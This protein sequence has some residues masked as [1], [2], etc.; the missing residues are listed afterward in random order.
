MTSLSQSAFL[1]ALGWAIAN[2]L[3]QMALLWAAYQLC[4]VVFRR[5]LASVKT[6]AATLLLFTGF[7][8]FLSSLIR[9]YWLIQS[10]MGAPGAGASEGTY[11]W[12][13][14]G[15]GGNSF[16]FYLNEFLGKSE[17]YL[18]YLSFAYLLVLSFLLIRVGKAY[19]HIQEIR[20][21]GLAKIDA[22]WRVYVRDL[23]YRLG[24]TREIRV[25][26]SDKIDIPATVGYLKPLVL[27]PIASFNHLTTEQIEAILLHELAHIKRHDYLL[28]LVITVVETILFFNP[29]AQLITRHIKTE[30]ENCCDDFVLQFQFSPRAYAAALLSLE[31]QR[32]APELAMM[33]AGKTDLMDR[34]KRIM[35]V[36][37]SPMNYGQKLMALVITACILSSLAWLT[38]GV[39]P[40][41]AAGPKDMEAL[42]SPA[43]MSQ[44]DPVRPVDQAN[45]IDPANSVDPASSTEQV[46][47]VDRAT[48]AISKPHHKVASHSCSKNSRVKGDWG[49][50]MENSDNTAET[51]QNQE[52]P[53]DAVAVQDSNAFDNTSSN[54]DSLSSPLHVVL[55]MK[56][57]KLQ[58]RK[59]GA[60]ELEMTMGNERLK[61]A[62]TRVRKELSKMNEN[63][64]D[65]WQTSFQNNLEQLAQDQLLHQQPGIM[66]TQR[67]YKVRK[68]ESQQD[69]YWAGIQADQPG[70]QNPMDEA[71]NTHSRAIFVPVK[72]NTSFKS[73]TASSSRQPLYRERLTLSKPLKQLSGTIKT[74]MAQ[75]ARHAYIDYFLKKLAMDG[76]LPADSLIRIV[77][78]DNALIINDI[79][80]PKAVFCRY[81]PY[82]SGK[83]VTIVT[84]GE[85]IQ[86]TIN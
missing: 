44:V 31:K 59:M 15:L 11:S 37:T 48:E 28:N 67:K 41:K 51:G 62:L 45:S 52:V 40:I 46:S 81:K 30:R 78:D 2:S 8:W 25:W 53:S 3:W 71:T 22:H 9:H 64:S 19:R 33:A 76:V 7:I 26:L 13:A 21:E 72:F 34:I 56:K 54:M 39:T 38:P 84:T 58:M 23:A 18:P 70:W 82:F 6:T 75:D 61:L 68:A 14:T 47:P 4:F 35:N 80:Q 24:I 69:Q 50:M 32:M 29:F 27:L 65:E 12:V 79:I 55:D 86:L 83:S 43:L 5:A 1:Q 66:G 16:R 73:P 85:T 60:H 20:S 77:R 57:A 36:Q 42:S 49:N 74:D 17:D 10:T 63:Q